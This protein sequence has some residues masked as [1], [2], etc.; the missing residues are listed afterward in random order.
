M[1]FSGPP[2][3]TAR[4]CLVVH[5]V[6]TL[7][8]AD[9]HCPL[10]AVFYLSRL[11]GLGRQLLIA[12]GQTSPNSIVLLTTMIHTDIHLVGIQKG[13]IWNLPSTKLH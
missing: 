8:Q 10:L 3:S 9:T 2:G 1:P 11:T 7:R 4:N 12:A 5:I 13:E 6:I